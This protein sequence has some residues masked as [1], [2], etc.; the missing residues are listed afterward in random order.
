MQTAHGEGRFF[1]GEAEINRLLVNKQ[2]VFRYT[3]P[4]LS[5]TVDYPDNPNG[6]VDNI[7]GI[8]DPSGVVLGMMPHPERSIGAFHPCADRAG[9]SSC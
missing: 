4:D 7:A 3:T 8:C 9:S 2:V 1:G 6:A 5:E